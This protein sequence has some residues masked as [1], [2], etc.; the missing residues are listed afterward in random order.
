MA[1][2]ATINLGVQALDGG[3]SV[4]G[5][6][7]V[8]WSNGTP[9]PLELI[10]TQ[11]N[12]GTGYFKEVPWEGGLEQ[13]LNYQQA[14]NFRSAWNRDYASVGGVKN[15][16][17]SVDTQTN[18]ITITAKTGI[19]TL[20]EYTGDILTFGQST[21][22]GS[23]ST[24]VT[25]SSAIQNTGDCNTIDYLV[26]ASNELQPYS[27]KVDGVDILT[28]WD[29]SQTTIQLS[30]LGFPPKTLTLHDASDELASKTEIV[31]RQLIPSEFK[32]DTI[33]FIGYSDIEIRE[34]NPV[35][36]TD[37]M[38]A[39]ADTD[40][41]NK[42]TYQGNNF[43]GILDGTYRL[44]IRD[45]YGCEVFK[46]ISVT[47]AQQDSVENFRQLGASALN[48][49]SFAKPVDFDAFNKKNHQ[50]TIS[51]NENVP[52]RHTGYHEFV[53][54]DI[55]K[56]Q[57]WSS[58]PF[59]VVTLRK[60]D[61]TIQEI[62]FDMIQ[63]NLGSTER[64]DCKLFP[65]DGKIGVY[66]DGGNEYEPNTTTIIDA[67]EHTN[68]LPDW[69]NVGQQVSLV[70]QGVKNIEEIGFDA[71]LGKSY[72]TI[73]GSIPSAED[74]IIQV[75]YNRQE[76]NLF[77]FY[78]SM[79]AVTNIAWITIEAGFE[80]DE[81]DSYLISEPMRRVSD[82]DDYLLLEWEGDK[83]IGNMV[84]T[85]TDMDSVMRVKGF[86]RPVPIGESETEDVDDRAYALLQESGVAMRA[87]IPLLTFN[88]WDKLN[89]ASSVSVAGV[90]K[91][92]GLELVRSSSMEYE[93]LGSTNYSNVTLEFALGGE[94]SSIKQDEIVTNP[95]TGVIGSGG[96]GKSGF[97]PTPYDGKLRLTLG[98]E[99]ITI[100]GNFVTLE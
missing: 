20:I 57:F 63:E 38:Y 90:F 51:A 83:N 100:G 55:I 84:Y 74:D 30:R 68:S 25:L 1:S 61:G 6:V 17:A 87:E 26:S 11:S 48:S 31:P 81:I 64:V 5:R 50:N 18:V 67:S 54:N 22:N 21:N 56:T 15:L 66:F 4:R 27:L 35:E 45:K 49:L 97:L 29:G 23:I 65:V 24:T 43:P 40:G 99:F 69:A 41:S 71:V 3:Q 33:P 76:Y 53:E 16:I 73:S 2:T 72:F 47:S 85:N 36:N 52:L 89:K 58:Y 91:I 62:P 34:V 12:L 37:P 98:G 32:Q 28:G 13:S 42:G 70:G 92:N 96:S 80:F 44:Y 82:N 8:T 94:N 88:Q 79:Q 95:S 46:T 59:M 86:I 78:L 77:Q 60:C 19:F 9:I 75:I 39:L 10:L 7:R 93:E 14:V